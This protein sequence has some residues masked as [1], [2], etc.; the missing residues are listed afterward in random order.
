M[1]T[2]VSYEDYAENRNVS[3]FFRLEPCPLL[4][5]FLI[6]L[7][8]ANNHL[9]RLLRLARRTGDRLI[10]TDERGSEEPL[11][12]LPLDEYEALIDGAFGPG[13]IEEGV[14]SR[15]SA[16]GGEEAFEENFVLTEEEEELEDIQ[17]EDVPAEIEP[18]PEALGPD[19]ADVDEE[20]L[21]SLWVKPEV[22][23]PEEKPKEVQKKPAGN[24]G[25]GE[26]G[27]YLESI[28]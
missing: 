18:D 24:S 10:V 23:K 20:A 12:I 2:D 28:D 11:V 8:M 26:E 22:Q 19:E 15:R 3:T 9:N 6:W 17:I 21:K 16:V 4:L 25:D 1:G 7:H 5:H 27:F 13:E 14:G